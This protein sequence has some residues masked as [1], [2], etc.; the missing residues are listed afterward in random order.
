MEEI[1]N[2]FS[3]ELLLLADEY[4]RCPNITLKKQIQ[5]DIQLLEGVIELYERHEE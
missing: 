3:N 5:I 2:I 1:V 4:R